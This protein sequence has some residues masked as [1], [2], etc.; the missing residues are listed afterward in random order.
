MKKK[1]IKSFLS[2]IVALISYLAYEKMPQDQGNISS[3][4]D[5]IYSKHAKCRMK[6]RYI[7][8]AEVQ[9]TLA[10]GKINHRKSEMNKKPCPVIA[11]EFYSKK[12]DQRIRVIAAEC[13]S[14]KTIITVI[15]LSRDHDCRCD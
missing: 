15:D 3:A 5:I 6:C 11:K 10:H 8:A 13:K 7:D 9:H 4:I 14:K 2:I 12:D 1:A